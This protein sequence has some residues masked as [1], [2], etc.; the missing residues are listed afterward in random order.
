MESSNGLRHTRTGAAD[1][2]RIIVELAELPP[3]AL[4]TLAG[5]AQIFGKSPNSIKRAVHE[6]RLP[7]PFRIF[8]ENFWRAG[9]LDGF[10]QKRMRDAQQVNLEHPDPVGPDLDPRPLQPLEEGASPIR[11]ESHARNP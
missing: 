4:L 10:L 1:D 11:T 6:G 9:E 5:M 8:S 3:G 7:K 2:L